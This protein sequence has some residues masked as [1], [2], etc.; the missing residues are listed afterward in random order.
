M[1]KIHTF[2]DSHSSSVHSHWG[3]IDISGVEIKCN[4]IGGRLMYTFGRM[5]MQLLDIRKYGVKENDTVIFC[6]GEIDCRNHVHKHIT[7]QVS[8]KD[9]IDYVATSYF[10]AI[11][12]NVSNYSNLKTC[13]YNVVPPSKC[14]NVGPNH[15]YPFIGTDDERKTY[16]MY[17]NTKLKELCNEH[18]FIYFDIYNDTCDDE[19]FLKK[20]YSDG[21]VHLRNTEHSTEFIIKHL[22][23]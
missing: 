21:Q 8:Y 11:K 7:E 12:E 17:M 13:V 4:H 3:K 10:K 14:F 9:V 18:N 5:G 1:V 23:D 15:P 16:H 2:G 22:L 20:E 6:F 19:G